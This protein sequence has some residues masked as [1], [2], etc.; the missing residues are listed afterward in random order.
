MNQQ[1]HD[2]ERMLLEAIL[3]G[4]AILGLFFLIMKAYWVAQS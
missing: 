4:I 3:V 1:N 2:D